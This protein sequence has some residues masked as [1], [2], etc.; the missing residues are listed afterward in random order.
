[1]SSVSSRISRTN[2]PIVVSMGR[3]LQKAPPNVLSLAQG[4][5]YW[6]PPDTAIARAESALKDLKNSRYGP[7]EGLVE[8]RQALSSRLKLGEK[9]RVMVRVILDKLC[10]DVNKR[11]HAKGIYRLLKEPIKRLLMLYW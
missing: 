11:A 5:V 2:A 3:L 9:E 4:Q 10:V 7:D 1:M 6:G 8:L